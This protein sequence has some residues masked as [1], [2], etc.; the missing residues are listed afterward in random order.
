MIN[1]KTGFK[2]PGIG[3]ILTNAERLRMERNSNTLKSESFTKAC[4]EVGIPYTKRQE[5]KWNM[6][7]VQRINSLINP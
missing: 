7:K 5:S 4:D 3:Y 2:T 6:K 1:R